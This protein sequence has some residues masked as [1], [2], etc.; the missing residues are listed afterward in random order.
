MRASFGGSGTPYSGISKRFKG[1]AEEQN[2]I[3]MAGI[4]DI[5]AA[6]LDGELRGSG[7]PVVLE[8]WIRSCSVCQR[9]K[10]VY[11]RLPEAMGHV[12]FL[13]INMMKSIEN[14]RLAEGMGVEETP[15][16][17]VFCRWEEVGEIVGYR[18]LEE[19]VREIEGTLRGTECA[20]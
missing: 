1:A 8:F 19:A 2:L 10:P 12:R 9:F 15:T 3:V 7:G 18:S 11:E 13:R 6:D 5:Q 16:T 14:L 20:P 17:K 4:R